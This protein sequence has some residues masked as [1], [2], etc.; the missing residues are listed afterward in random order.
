MPSDLPSDHTIYHRGKRGESA[1]SF[2]PALIALGVSLV[3][4]LATGAAMAAQWPTLALYWYAPRATGS[5]ADP[6]LAGRSNFYLFTLPAWQLIAGWLL[7]LAVIACVLAVLFHAYLGRLPRARRT[8]AA[9][10]CAYPGAG[11]PSRLAFLLLIIGLRVYV[12]R[13]E[14][15]FDHHTIFD[16][17]TYTDAHVTL[18]G[19]LF[20]CAALVL[21]A[22]IALAG[23]RIRAARALAG[24]G[25]CFR[26]W[27]VMPGCG[28]WAGTSP[29]S[30]SSPT[31]WF[32]S[33]PTSPTTSR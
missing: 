27:S 16:G 17:V 8:F 14:Q 10:R 4:A 13:F 24:G 22:V 2:G 1:G 7:T 20:V 11:S 30:L 21:G 32:A 29:A 25:H 6:I 15:L 12:S 19:M 5:V 26:P 33:S 3:I 18:T 9:A 31:N 28:W 23:A